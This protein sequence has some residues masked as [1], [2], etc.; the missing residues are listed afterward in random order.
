MAKNCV[1]NGMYVTKK[2]L[3]LLMAHTI[4][5]ISIVMMIQNAKTP[6]FMDKMEI[7]VN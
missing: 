7:L 2:V 6:F 3:I 1:L 4:K 5:N